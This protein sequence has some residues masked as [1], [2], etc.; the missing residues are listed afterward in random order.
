MERSTSLQIL[1]IFLFSTS[2]LIFKRVESLKLFSFTIFE[3]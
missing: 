2:D 3:K 1:V